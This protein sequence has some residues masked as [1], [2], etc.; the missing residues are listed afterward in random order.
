MIVYVRRCWGKNSIEWNGPAFRSNVFRFVESL[1]LARG[2]QESALFTCEGSVRSLVRHHDTAETL[3]EEWHMKN[4][5]RRAPCKEY[6]PWIDA[7]IAMLG[8][9]S[10]SI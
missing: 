7:S 2:L 3:R 8:L 5:A 6:V 9:D 10:V 1:F 4:N